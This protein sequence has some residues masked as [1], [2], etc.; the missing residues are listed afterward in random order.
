M[1]ASGTTTTSPTKPNAAPATT[2]SRI[3][4]AGCRSAARPCTRGTSRL[5]STC[6]TATYSSATQISRSGSV[7]ATITIPGTAPS[8]GPM[9]GISSVTPA[10]S[11]R[12]SENLTF[13]NVS[14]TPTAVP[15]MNP[16][17]ICPRM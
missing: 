11:P 16:R 7:A 17:K 9:I 15:T 3:T 14:P 13:M 12:A 1:A 5:F 8:Q 6:C 4:M 10:I 2:S